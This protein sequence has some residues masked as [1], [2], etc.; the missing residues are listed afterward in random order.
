MKTLKT[1][2]VAIA[3]A[4]MTIIPVCV[5]SAEAAGSL[6]GLEISGGSSV[7]AQ[8]YWG[9]SLTRTDLKN[10]FGTDNITTRQYFVGVGIMSSANGSICLTKSRHGISINR[11]TGE[12]TF[13]SGASGSINDVNFYTHSKVTVSSNP[14]C[15]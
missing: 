2:I 11:V 12:G 3:I 10:C 6:T 4:M 8:L 15:Y 1:F 5:D 7:G 13:R 14:S 9:N